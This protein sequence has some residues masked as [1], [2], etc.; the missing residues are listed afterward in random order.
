MFGY[1]LPPVGRLGE[2]ERERFRQVYCGL[3][4]TLRRR[5]GLAARFIL[6]YDFTY[7]AVLLSE[8]EENPETAE[9]YCPASP[10]K[11]RCY[12]PGSAALDLAADE[13]VILAYWQL[14]DGIA[15]HGL[16]KGTGYRLG[17]ALLKN[18]YQKAAA[19]RS[20]FDATT[21]KQLEILS[22]L[23]REKSESLDA[24]ADTFATLL[25]AAADEIE[26]PVRRRVLYQLLYHLGRWVYLVD[27][28]DDL[29]KDTANGSYN[30]IALRYGITSGVMPPEVR[31]QF[32]VT[33]DHS[34]HMM[35]T[36][37]ELC[38]FGCWTELLSV[39]IYD[40]LFA[41]GKAVLD[42][43]FHEKQREEK[44]NRLLRKSHD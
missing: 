30:P 22:R 14:M 1:V 18:A 41:V 8:G 35:A 6:N 28:A 13:S 43:T 40:G 34:I 26:D 38:D 24:P 17:A 33:L 16:V 21:R 37:F 12:H 10:V 42:G 25:A 36:A 7:L 3:C 29:K 27:A 32:S 5:Y 23:E 11:K 39:T 19:R 15:D 4:H 44:K 31:R 9:G 20:G 2:E